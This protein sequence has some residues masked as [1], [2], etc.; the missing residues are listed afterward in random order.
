MCVPHFSQHIMPLLSREA[1]R[2][3]GNISSFQEVSAFA[4]RYLATTNFR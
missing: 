3:D 2:R 1:V 4:K